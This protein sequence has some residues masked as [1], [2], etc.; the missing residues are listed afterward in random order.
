M[1]FPA[2]ERDN[3]T[4]FRQKMVTLFRWGMEFFLDARMETLV[5]HLTSTEEA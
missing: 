2:A 1:S 5:I 4:I 3:Q